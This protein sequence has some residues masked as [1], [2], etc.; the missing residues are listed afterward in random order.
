MADIDG[1]KMELH[2]LNVNMLV[3]Y[4]YNKQSNMSNSK[5]KKSTLQ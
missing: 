4:L 2:S 5:V 1:Q 3:T